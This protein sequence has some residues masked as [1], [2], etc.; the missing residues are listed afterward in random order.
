MTAR[1][2]TPREIVDRQ[3]ALYN[4][5]D[6]EPYLALF[7]AAA[8]LVDLPSG[9][10]LARGIEDIRALYAARF[11]NPDLYC[12][13]HAR[14]ELGTHAIDRETLHGLPGGPVE[15]LALYE[16]RQGLITRIHFLREPTRP[17]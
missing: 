15:V 12:R 11:A 2:P 4:A 9:K 13:V 14:M 3:L 1:Q 6:L 5:R 16:V 17:A 7:D 8:E 10:V